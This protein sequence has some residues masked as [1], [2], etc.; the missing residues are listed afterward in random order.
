M[1]CENELCVYQR[2]GNRLLDEIVLDNSGTCASCMLIPFSS[3]MIE[4]QKAQALQ[5]IENR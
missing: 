1:R 4:E 5:E 2:N 3:E